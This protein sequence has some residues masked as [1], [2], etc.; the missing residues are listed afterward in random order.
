MKAFRYCQW[1]FCMLVATLRAWWAGAS[2]AWKAINVWSFYPPYDEETFM[3]FFRSHYPAEFKKMH[4]IIDGVKR[5]FPER[6]GVVGGG[7]R[8]NS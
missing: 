4:C 2:I 5:K 3:E 8:D 1:R 7:G 6:Y